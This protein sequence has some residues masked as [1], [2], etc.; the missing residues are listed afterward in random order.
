V[1]T[2]W[3]GSIGY[4]LSGGMRVSFNVDRQQRNSDLAGY[5]YGGL[6]FGTSVNYGF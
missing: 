3:G 6:R 4:R 2:L 1:M 5:S